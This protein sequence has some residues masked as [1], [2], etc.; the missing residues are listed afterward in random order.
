MRE[1]IWKKLFSAEGVLLYEGYTL[2]DKAC[3]EGTAFYS[4]GQLYK[5]GVFDVKGLVK[6]K[7]YYPNG[8]L[9]FDGEYVVQKGYGPNFP[10]GGTC[11]D[12]NGN[13]LEGSVTVRKSGS[14]YPMIQWP[15]GCERIPD[16][17]RPDIPI[18]MWNDLAMTTEELRFFVR[19]ESWIF[20]KTYAQKAPHEY[21]VRN[22]INGSDEDF[23]AMV[24]YIQENGIIMYFWNH[25][26]KY[27]FL[28]GY[29]YWVMRENEEDPSTII[30]RCNL[31]E[32]KLS[33]TW[34]DAGN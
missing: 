5:E 29:Q 13:V 1:L 25:P 22:K 14:G 26:N 9:R 23:M 3:G 32:Y 4:D 17:E 24:D 16:E 10:K 33:I 8:S 12:P 21:I 34:K 31:N 19:N 20:A 28:D 30:N 15:K 27:I 2:H 18:L 7:E 6:G 11:Y